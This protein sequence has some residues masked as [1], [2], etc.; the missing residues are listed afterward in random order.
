MRT[1]SIAVI[2]VL[3]AACGLADLGASAATTAKIQSEQVKQGKETIKQVQEKLDAVAAAR[4]RE[5]REGQNES[6]E[7]KDDR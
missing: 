3:L 4:E 2:C 1:I 7:N 6:A 5:L